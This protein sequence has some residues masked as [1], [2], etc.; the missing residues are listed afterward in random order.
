MKENIKNPY[1]II[2]H[3]H[4]TEKSRVLQELKN[5]SS[6]PSLKK[7][8]SPKYVFVVDKNANKSEIAGAVE[9]IYKD[10]NVKVVKVNT[11][12]VKGKKRRLRGKP[13]MTAS[14]KKAVVT[15]D[16]GDNLD[17]V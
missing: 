11:I 16:I 13:G 4:V 1:A 17:L 2:K 15:L 9:A 3:L 14:I 12:H 5:A 8:E 6:N 10:K 7:C